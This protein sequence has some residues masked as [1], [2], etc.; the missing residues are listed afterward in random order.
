MGIID[1]KQMKEDNICQNLSIYDSQWW[2]SIRP[3]QQ[4]QSM[5]YFAEQS[6]QKKRNINVICAQEDKN[7]SLVSHLVLALKRFMYSNQHRDVDEA[8]EAK[9]AANLKSHTRR[10]SIMSR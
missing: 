4:Y 6:E 2:S 10:Q 7:G 8:L 5:H 3:Y 9:S 1:M